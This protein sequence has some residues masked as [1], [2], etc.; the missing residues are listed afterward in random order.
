MR[1]GGLVLDVDVDAYGTV[2]TDVLSVINEARN[3]EEE[4][5]N[6]KAKVE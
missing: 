1:S 6:E 3:H 2:D 5:S 4:C